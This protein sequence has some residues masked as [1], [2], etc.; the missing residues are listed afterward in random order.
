LG[1]EDE[2]RMLQEAL[3]KSLNESLVPLPTADEIGKV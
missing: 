1:E 2:E 3:K